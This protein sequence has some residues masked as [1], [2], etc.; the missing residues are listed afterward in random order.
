[1]EQLAAGARGAAA[2]LF[3][4]AVAALRVQRAG[5]P[6]AEVAAWLESFEGRRE[7][8]T[9]LSLPI[10][11][12]CPQDLEGFET[13]IWA[14]LRLAQ[15]QAEAVVA[16]LERVLERMIAQGRQG[17]A[18]PVRALL[19][20]LYWEAGRP[21]QAVA[22]LEPA[23]ALAGREGYVRVF[24]EGGDALAP[25]LGACAERGIAPEYAGKLLA[26]LESSPPFPVPL[27]PHPA[28]ASAPTAAGRERPKVG[29]MELVEPLTDRELEVL[30]LAADGL[31]NE[32]IAARLFLSVGTV[33]RHLHNTYGKLGVTGRFNAVVRAREL[34]LL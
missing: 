26:A 32:A 18:L 34:G 27:S 5:T 15:G 29:L 31:S 11:G 3:E 2:P 4:P 23:L 19:A 16:R 8:K 9:L 33:K 7:S 6:A 28:P 14:R 1:L 13:V 21:E 12:Y 10:S 17:S 30:G 22:V 24:L 20:T 25:V